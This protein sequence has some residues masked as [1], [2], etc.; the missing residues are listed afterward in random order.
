[1]TRPGGE[2]RPCDDPR[3]VY[4]SYAVST[5][6]HDAGLRGYLAH[7]VILGG[8]WVLLMKHSPPRVSPAGL[9]YMYA[10]SETGLPDSPGL[11]V[12]ESRLMLLSETCP[13]AGLTL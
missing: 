11:G 8:G 5:P 4:V 6:F 3:G 1:M 10:W 7:T 12:G 2:P 9:P 13:E